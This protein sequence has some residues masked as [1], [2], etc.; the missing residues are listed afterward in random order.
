MSIT[1]STLTSL[2]MSRLLSW[3]QSSQGQSRILQEQ[4]RRNFSLW[5]KAVSPAWSW[6][7]PYLAYIRQ[8][9]DK[10]TRGEISRLMLF[11]PPRHGKS[12]MVTIRYPVWRLE[13]DPTMR[14]IIA[15]YNQTLAEKFSR[16]S[17]KIARTRFTL[18][19]ERTATE[20]WETQ[21]GGGM[22][23]VGVGGG[24]TGQ[25]GNL[26][27][28]D[29]PVK[30]RE[31]AESQTYR[32]RVWD[33]FTD[34]LYTRLEPGGS[35]I[36]I[37]TRWHE[38]DLAGRILASDSGKQ[39]TV[40]NLPAEAEESDPLGRAVGQP[41]CPERFDEGALQQ[42]RSVLG[43]YSY[44]AL[45]QQRPRPRE[46]GMFKREWL[47]QSVREAPVQ[48]VR[49]RYWDKA[50][51]E[52]AGDYSAGVLMARTPEGLVFVED[53][54]RG[55]WS[56]FQREQ[57]IR[58]TAQQDALKYGNRVHQWFEQEGGSG[59]KE[60]AQI[61][62]RS[63]AG[64]P[65]H[66]DPAKGDKAVRAMPFAAQCEAGNVRLVLGLWNREYSDELCSF[67]N[68]RNDD[69]VDGSSGAYNKLALGVQRPA[70]SFQG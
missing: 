24:I 35:M 15:A 1:R 2:P 70:R 52:G 63:L 67:P 51:T 49:V 39:W 34:D 46:G 28:I 56:A 29:D 30:S 59:G 60:S 9:L 14:V 47:S 37:Q 58:Q 50:A 42:I 21:Q 8:H 16:W 65:V 62:I 38:D 64:V 5:L 31:E 54:V 66:A 23:A 3:L 40:V 36:V 45:Y 19:E 10:L 48:A 26:I 13:R 55:Q 68:G 6:D 17:R 11:L 20:D 53:V 7:W 43:S 44:W 25:G 27:I 33:W 32:D 57:I 41:L 12:Q 18:N 4:Q 61:S 22:R 69:Q